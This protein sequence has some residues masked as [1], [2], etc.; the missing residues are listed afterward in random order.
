MLKRDSA[1]RA[2]SSRST[3]ASTV[4]PRIQHEADVAAVEDAA[5]QHLGQRDVAHQRSRPP[6]TSSAAIAAQPTE[7]QRPCARASAARRLRRGGRRRQQHPGQQHGGQQREAEQVHAVVEADCARNRKLRRCSRYRPVAT[8]GQ[9]PSTWYTAGRQQPQ[10]RDQREQQR[11]LVPQHRRVGLEQHDPDQSP[12]RSTTRSAGAARA[13][14]ASISGSSETTLRLRQL[15]QSSSGSSS[16]AD[17]VAASAA[18]P[19]SRRCTRRGSAARPRA[20]VVSDCSALADGSRLAA[21]APTA[22]ASRS[23]RGGGRCRRS[24]RRRPS[25]PP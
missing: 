4:T 24:R 13:S 19:R 21:T 5:G 17:C 1:R 10:H 14:T 22:A 20:P 16:S 11:R 3:E 8:Y 15:S 25:A 12:A 9:G 18:S 2:S 6:R 23:A 7:A